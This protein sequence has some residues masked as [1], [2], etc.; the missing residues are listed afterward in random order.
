MSIKIPERKLKRGVAP[1]AIMYLLTVLYL[2]TVS[3]TTVIHS[4]QSSEVGHPPTKPRTEIPS[5]QIQ[6]FQEDNEEEMW[7]FRLFQKITVSHQ[8]TAFSLLTL[9]LPQATGDKYPR[10]NNFV[11]CHK[12]RKP[13]CCAHV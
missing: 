6:L 9:D 5:P 3:K 12:S 4:T 7:Y 1:Q 13:S 8:A 11:I 10:T 2:L